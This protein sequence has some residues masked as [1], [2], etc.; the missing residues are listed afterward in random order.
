MLEIGLSLMDGK[1]WGN[2]E[3]ESKWSLVALKILSF[4]PELRDPVI[5]PR[6]PVGH[7]SSSGESDISLHSVHC[8][9]CVHYVHCVQC[10][11]CALHMYQMLRPVS[12]PAIKWQ[13]TDRI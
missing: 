1:F 11:Q 4:H 10:A 6:M 3:K 9:H 13:S 2:N 12:A 5:F 8:V 7:C